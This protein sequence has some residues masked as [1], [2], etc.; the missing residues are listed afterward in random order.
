MT[1]WYISLGKNK[2]TR[3][4]Y[5]GNGAQ[6]HGES[7]VREP[8]HRVKISPSAVQA[9][10]HR[11]ICCFSPPKPDPALFSAI[12][13]ALSASICSAG[14]WAMGE[15]RNSSVT[16]QAALW[17]AYFST[18]RD[19]CVSVILCHSRLPDNNILSPLPLSLSYGVQT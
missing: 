7:R 15:G 18:A 19:L 14:A 9:Y 12:V 6:G 2:R 16:M 8:S 13:A 3:L 11:A 10:V 17:F 4:K 1:T 5:E